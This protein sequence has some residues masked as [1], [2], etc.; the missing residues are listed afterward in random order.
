MLRYAQSTGAKQV[1]LMLLNTSWGRGNLKVAEIYNEAHP[2]LKIVGSHWYN[3]D[4]KS[5]IDKYQALRQAGAEAIVL[6]SNT[7]DAAILIKEVAALPSNQRIPL[8]AHWGV[9]GGRLPEIAGAALHQVDFSV[10]QTY[11]FI[12]DVSPKA[13]K[14]IATAKRLFGVASARTLPSPT[15]VAHGYDLTHIL[16]KAIN[17]AASTDREAIRDAL[18]QIS[19]YDG[20]VRNYK[21]PFTPSQHEALIPELVFMAKYAAEDNAIVRVW[22]KAGKSLQL[23]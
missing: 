20:L 22:P 12:D 10:V 3:W 2:D 9:A 16:A 18:E 19:N 6:V 8:I 13:L 1:G 17:D 5:L 21:R 11:S 15:G 14:V 4:D 23:Q 7:D